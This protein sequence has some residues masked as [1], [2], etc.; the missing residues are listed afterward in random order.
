M[1]QAFEGLVEE[2]IL[3]QEQVDALLEL[4]PEKGEGQGGSRGRGGEQGQRGTDLFESAI[5]AGIITEAD[6]EAMEIHREA[7]R[8]DMDAVKEA[9]EGMTRDEAKAYMEET[10]GPKP[11]PFEG[12]VEDGILT[13]EQ[14]DELI[15]LAP[16]RPGQGEGGQ[17]QRGQGG[18]REGQGA[19]GQGGQGLGRPSNNGTSNT[20][21]L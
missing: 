12:L 4:A 15:E 11:E 16:E 17:G 20:N 14:V 19:K 3:S 5:E 2:G 21:S 8:P 6:L 10:Y 9:T 1:S 13:Q 18:R 7:N